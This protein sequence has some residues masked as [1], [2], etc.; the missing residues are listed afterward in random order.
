[1]KGQISEAQS[2]Q[3]IYRLLGNSGNM[4][5]KFRDSESSL[6]DLLWHQFLL[7]RQWDQSSSFRETVIPSN[8][9]YSGQKKGISKKPFAEH[10]S[11]FVSEHE[12]AEKS[13][14]LRTTRKRNKLEETVKRL[15]KA[16]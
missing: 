7:P 8:R 16:F 10:N 1:M 14:Q 6:G 13:P 15:L 3:E 4:K 2:Q 11:E 9:G 12:E 5:E